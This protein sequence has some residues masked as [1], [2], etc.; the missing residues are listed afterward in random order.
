MTA[1]TPAEIAA[2]L[3]PAQKKAL[4]WLHTM[5]HTKAGWTVQGKPVTREPFEQWSHMRISG[6]EGAILVATDDLNAMTDLTKPSLQK[7]RV[8]ELSELG[9]LVRA[10]LEK[11]AAR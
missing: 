6:K 1:P 11:E 4:E 7:D 9:L 5:P 8:W 10:E 3:S 2:K